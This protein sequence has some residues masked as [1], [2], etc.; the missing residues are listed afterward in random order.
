MST[1]GAEFQSIS[2]AWLIL[3]SFALRV[4]TAFAGKGND[5]MMGSKSVI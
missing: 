5:G 3:F 2:N 1:L 4:R